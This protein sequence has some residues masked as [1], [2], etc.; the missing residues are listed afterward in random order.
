MKS[1]KLTLLF[2]FLLWLIPFLV[3]IPI[4]SLKEAQSPLFETIMPVT[5]TLFV[6]LFAVLYFRRVDGGFLA[7]AIKLGVIWMAM[8]IIIDLFMFMWGPMKMSFTAYMMDIGLTYLIFPI[9]TVGFG[10]ALSKRT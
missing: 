7:E 5:L 8:S 2:G 10:Y 4:F 1:W 6:T 3:S 9:V